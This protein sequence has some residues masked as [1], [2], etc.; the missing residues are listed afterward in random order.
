MF[1]RNV[2]VGI[3]VTPTA[4]LVLRDTLSSMDFSDNRYEFHT[5]ATPALFKSARVGSPQGN[6]AVFVQQVVRFL[7]AI[8]SSWYTYLHES[9]VSA[10]VPDV[11]GNLAGASLEVWDGLLDRSDAAE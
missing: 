11:I 8:G 9:A 1:L 6:D 3:I 7:E 2:R 4:L 5:L 10:M